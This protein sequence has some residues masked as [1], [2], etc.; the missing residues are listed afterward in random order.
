VI[1]SVAAG[2]AAANNYYAQSLLVDMAVD[3][4]I[5][6]AENA[7]VAT[8]AQLGLMLGVLFLL[9]LG[10]RFERRQILIYS[11][12]GTAIAA[13]GIAFTPNFALLF[14]FSF[15]LGLMTLI[16]YL[17]PPFAAQLANQQERGRILGIVLTGQ[18]TGILLARLVSGTLA[19][20]IGWRGVYVCAA[21]AMVLL[22]FVFQRQLP[23]QHPPISLEYGQLLRS[24]WPLMQRHRILRQ[25]CL[26]QAMLFG[27]FIACWCGLNF[28]VAGP[29]YYF[30]SAAT[31]LF[32]LVGLCSILAARRVGR[33]VD[34]YGA[35][36]IVGFAILLTCV[37]VVCLGLLSQFLWGLVLG[38]CLL[39]LGIQSAF[40]ANQTRVFGLDANARNRLG[41]LFFVSAFLGGA[42]GSGLV[43]LTWD[44]GG[45]TAVCGI[46]GLFCAIATFAHLKSPPE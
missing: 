1:L 3:L 2:V 33:W 14:L 22:M 4:G 38:F 8:A 6:K 11:A 10:D 43:T 25:S 24:L 29:P 19:E 41:T 30:G 16:P 42:L 39:D 31:G 40:I 26:I 36:L 15:G 17:L 45:W 23:L 20:V 32:G 46:G 9:P 37:S 34:R 18:F 28:F 21:I 7:L 27:S 5:P 13:L 12:L 44:A 35:R